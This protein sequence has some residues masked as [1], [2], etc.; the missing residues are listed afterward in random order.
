[1]E[2]NVVY[3]L[4]IDVTNGTLTA[5]VETGDLF[6]VW[7]QKDGDAAP[8]TMLLQDYIS[9]RSPTG[10]PAG[11]GG[12]L[13]RAILDKLIVGFND[14]SSL[15]FDDFYISKSGYN[16]TIPRPFGFTTPIGQSQGT[17][18]ITVGRNVD[19]V[20]ITYSNGTLQSSPSVTGPWNPVA[21]ATSPYD[22]TPSGTEQYFQVKQ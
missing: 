17:P 9:D 4:W 14:V 11:A 18:T 5:G 22:V 2:S 21:G 8:R 12:T 20:R 16:A 6:T 19:K 13:T 3:N 1:L 10:D 15:L 7:I